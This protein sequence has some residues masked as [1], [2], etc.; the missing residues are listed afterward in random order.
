MNKTLQIAIGIVIIVVI[1]VLIVVFTKEK[2]TEGEV[3]KIGAI[4]PLTGG[5]ADMGENARNGIEMA[6][7]ELRGQGK[8]IS[9]IYE[10]DQ[11]DPQ[12][13]LSAFNKLVDIDAVKYV[14]TLG[15]NNGNIIGP[16]AQEQKIVHFSISTDLK[17]LD[18]S[19]SLKNGSDPL[20]L[21]RA[22]SEEVEKRN[23]ERIYIMASNHEG[24]LSIINVFKEYNNI[25]ERIVG[26][27]L[28]DP[29]ESDFRTVLIKAK[30]ANPDAILLEILPGGVGLAAKQARQL[31]INVPLFSAV[32]FENQSAINAAE[33]SL[34]GQWYVNSHVS[35]EFI[36]EYEQQYNK[37]PSRDAANGYDIVVLINQA[38]NKVGDDPLKVNDYL[39]QLKD[40]ESHTIEGGIRVKNGNFINFAIV[41]IIKNGQ[42]VPLEDF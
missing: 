13:T 20:E 26:E 34:E 19:F 28:I 23:Y 36:D 6:L 24:S 27:E 4:L 21:A 38:I 25:K 29:T 1:V 10:D 33:G 35:N 3:I 9:V 32:L 39:H 2:P 11:Y 37:I 22:M 31:N 7:K 16:L 12:K 40:F 30:A 42:F 41:K 18:Y 15:S 8:D 17:V 5:G 14:I